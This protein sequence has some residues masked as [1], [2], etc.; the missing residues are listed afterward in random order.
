MSDWKNDAKE[1]KLDTAGFCYQCNKEIPA[2]ESLWV[3]PEGDALCAPCREKE[4]AK[5]A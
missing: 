3:V 2:G 5:A 4:C 1:E